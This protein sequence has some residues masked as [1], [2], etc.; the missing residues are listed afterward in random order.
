[1]SRLRPRHTPPRAIEIANT[2]L[3]PDEE[4]ALLQAPSDF[5]DEHHPENDQYIKGVEHIQRQIMHVNKQLRPKQVQILKT[6]FSGLNY[7]DTA[8]EHGTTRTTVSR[9]VKSTNGSRLLSLLHYHLKLIE[10][11]NEAQR[12]SMLWRIAAREEINN[13]KTSITALGELNKMHNFA[14]QLD[15]N[16]E[17]ANSPNSKAPTVIVNINQATM[18][19][20]SLD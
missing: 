13:P 7:T 14:K 18:P 6:V 4:D 5:L 2:D 9:L 11:P 20:G 1:M 10:G 16:A 12:R 19:K 8:K 17:L 15:Q 3:I